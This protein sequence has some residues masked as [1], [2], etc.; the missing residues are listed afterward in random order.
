MADILFPRIGGAIEPQGPQTR[1]FM[2]E[3][4]TRP[5]PTVARLLHDIAAGIRVLQT[6]GVEITEEQVLERARNIVTG[7][8]GNYQITGLED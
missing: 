4:R 7:L 2:A 6:Y 3:A 8:L 5:R 1:A